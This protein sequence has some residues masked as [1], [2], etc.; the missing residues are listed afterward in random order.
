V[1]TASDDVLHTAAYRDRSASWM[2]T[3]ND[4]S[5]ASLILQISSFVQ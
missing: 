1:F 5:L 3:F 2:N 4:V